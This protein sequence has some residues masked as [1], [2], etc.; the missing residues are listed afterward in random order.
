MPQLPGDSDCHATVGRLAG[1]AVCVS[2][3][4]CVDVREWSQCACKATLLAVGICEKGP[5]LLDARLSVCLL[6]AQS[7]CLVH[8]CGVRLL[9]VDYL[10]MWSVAEWCNCKVQQY[11]YP[12]RQGPIFLA[13]SE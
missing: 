6:L 13:N 5:I 8:C 12:M 1:W 4:M 10:K 11:R 9:L 3:Y 2:V 7:L